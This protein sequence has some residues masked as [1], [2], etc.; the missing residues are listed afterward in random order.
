M[1]SKFV[2]PDNGDVTEASRPSPT[3]PVVGKTNASAVTLRELPAATDTA[4]LPST[5]G[6]GFRAPEEGGSDRPFDIVRPARANPLSRT[7]PPPTKSG[8]RGKPST[9]SS[10]GKSAPG[11]T[12]KR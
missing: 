7:M 9:K 2:G 8:A 12:R 1:T 10:A 4:P 5:R 3:V 11:T 6:V